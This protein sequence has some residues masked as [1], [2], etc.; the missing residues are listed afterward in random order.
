MPDRIKF[1]KSRPTEIRVALPVEVAEEKAERDKFYNSAR[2]R[3]L[4]A[5]FIAR[6]PL[7]QR[8][9]AKGETTLAKVVHHVKERLNFPAL[10][11]T[12]SNLEAVC[13]KCHTVGHK[14]RREY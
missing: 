5:E 14:K 6:H 3:K 9:E 10:A 7:C 13:N 8:C 12:W 11:Y 4:R 2:W 1:A